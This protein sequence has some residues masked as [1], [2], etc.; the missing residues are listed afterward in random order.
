MNG[1]VNLRKTLATRR[2]VLT[3]AGAA[4]VAAGLPWP[5]S[6]A[7]QVIVGTWG[8]D[9]QALLTANFEKPVLEKKGIEVVHDVGNAPPRKTK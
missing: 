2:A 3:G 1:N 6:A 8:G 4:A 5:A 9:Y 7:G